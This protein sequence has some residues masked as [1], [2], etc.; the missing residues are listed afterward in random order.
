MFHTENTLYLKRLYMINIEK[1][2]QSPRVEISFIDIDVDKDFVK[3]FRKEFH[4]TQIALANVLGV[5]KKTVEKW[6]QGVN[7]VSGSSAVLLKLLNKNP[8]L[9]DQIY[10]VKYDVSGKN[11]N[12]YKIIESKTIQQ[13]TKP[14]KTSAFRLP[15]VAI[16]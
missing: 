5:T 10:S 4:L 16:Y 13:T 6:E 12:S 7:K 8:E 11:E 14:V 15:L 1:L 2:L 3:T 9:I